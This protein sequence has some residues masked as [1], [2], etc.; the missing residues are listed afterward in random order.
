MDAVVEGV[1]GIQRVTT[2]VKHLMQLMWM[3]RF[4]KGW[5]ASI[6]CGWGAIG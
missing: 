5:S 1:K 6:E 3:V 4:K 2:A